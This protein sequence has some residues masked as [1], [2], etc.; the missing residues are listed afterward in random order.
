MTSF[1]GRRGTRSRGNMGAREATPTPCRSGTNWKVLFAG[2]GAAIE[3]FLMSLQV[4]NIVSVQILKGSGQ[5]TQQQSKSEPDREELMIFIVNVLWT[6]KHYLN[7]TR[8]HSQKNISHLIAVCLFQN[9]KPLNEFMTVSFMQVFYCHGNKIPRF[10]IGLAPRLRSSDMT[11]SALLLG[12]VQ[13][14]M[15]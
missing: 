1:I 14:N 9:N 8:T 6:T 3:V 7:K 12:R 10:F 5:K 11:Q 13:S 2:K 4:W 15:S